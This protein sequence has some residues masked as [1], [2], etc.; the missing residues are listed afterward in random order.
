MGQPR[1]PTRAISG[2]NELIL[3][4]SS[5]ARVLAAALPLVPPARATTIGLESTV[6]TLRR[7]AAADDFW[8]KRFSARVLIATAWHDAF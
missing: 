8:G 6:Y 2:T 7:R 4:D 5:R 3:T 1:L